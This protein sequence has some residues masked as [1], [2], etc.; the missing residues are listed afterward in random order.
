MVIDIIVNLC[1]NIHTAICSKA[2]IFE[3]VS[4]YLI[5]ATNL[6]TKKEI[7]KK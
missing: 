2:M 7:N 3:K 6:F 1:G 4:K 5:S